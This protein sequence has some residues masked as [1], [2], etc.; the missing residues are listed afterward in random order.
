MFAYSEARMMRGRPLCLAMAVALAAGLLACRG[1]IE[2]VGESSLSQTV[3]DAAAPIS[4]GAIGEMKFAA[5]RS[6]RDLRTYPIA[7][8]LRV[9][10]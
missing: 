2:G 4:V 6:K 9:L 8:R 10:A 3:A 5:L 1:R 7:R